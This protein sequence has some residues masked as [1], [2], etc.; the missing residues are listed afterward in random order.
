M[1]EAQKIS[2]PGNSGAFVRKLIGLLGSKGLRDPRALVAAGVL[3]MLLFV[4]LV[5]KLGGREGDASSAGG[6]LTYKV[7][8]GDLLI[9]FLERGN[10]KAAKSV[11]IFNQL[12]GLNT[13][14]NLV[15]EG[16]FVKAGDILVEL[17]SSEIA[18][19][20]NQQQI[21]VDTGE[22]ALNQAEKQL[23][24][25]RSLNQSDLQQS[26]VNLELAEIDLEKYKDGDFEVAQKKAESDMTIAEQELARATNQCEWT[27]KLSVKGYV[28]GTELIADRLSVTKARLQLDQ[29]KRALEVLKKYT[30]RKDLKKF[31]LDLQLARAA[32][33]RTVLKANAEEGKLEADVSGKRSSS[34]H[35]QKRLKKVQEQLEKTRIVAPQDGMVVYA[36]SEPWR[37]ER[38]IEKG[39]QVH[40]NQILLS[41]PDVSTM[42]VDVQVHESWIDQVHDDLMALVSID[43]L[44]NLNLKGK[45]SKVGLL[46]DSVNRWLNPDLKVYLTEITLEDSP[47]I[48]LLRPGMS[49]KV[50]ILITL[51]KDVLYVP[52]QS[53]TTVDKQQVCYVLQ[54]KQFVPRAVE[55]GKYNE[56]YIEILSGLQ[57]GDILQLNAP[58]PQGGTQMNGAEEASA[59]IAAGAASP[60]E[61]GKGDRDADPRSKGKKGKEEKKE[62]RTALRP[63][64]E[65]ADPPADA[66][67]RQEKTKTKRQGLENDPGR[68]IGDGRSPRKDKEAGVPGKTKDSPAVPSIP[69]AGRQ[70]SSADASAGGQ[71]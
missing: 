11:Q 45:V 31:E 71:Q 22:A 15:P 16:T 51:L 20:L 36:N 19:Q 34:L 57:E 2:A 41:L 25:Q 69:P 39:A 48:K 3:G 4:L 58:A 32:L 52:V 61:Q 42:A 64:G 18:Q 40:E 38:M 54:G 12:E 67:G 7:T 17:D 13:I 37:R 55:G 46:P 6:E 30:S 8:R 44:P 27:E 49:A 24:I 35:Y 65:F 21:Q 56:S 14:V 29:A 28:T 23:E 63:P 43:A 47:D 53:M 68:V 70:A 10:I 5:V 1:T 33:D 50:T 60:G 62:R 66:F 9:S 59:A 26:K